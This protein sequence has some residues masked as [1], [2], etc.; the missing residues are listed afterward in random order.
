M[1]GQTVIVSVLADTKKFNSAMAGTDRALNRFAGSLR[2]VSRIGS[3]AFATVTYAVGRFVVASVQAAEEAEAVD[4]KLVNQARNIKEL[5][6]SYKEVSARLLGVAEVQQRLLGVDDD[7][8]KSTQTILL[9]FRPLAKLAGE[10]GGA[11]DR[12][13]EAAFNLAELGF[14]TAEGNA[15]ALGKAL[16]NPTKGLGSLTRLGVVFTEQQ[17]KQIAN[18]DKVGKEAEAYSI[19]LG[20]IEEQSA[21]AG[22]VGVTATQKLTTAWDN[23]QEAFGKRILPTLTPAIE[24]LSIALYDLASSPEF[25]EFADA[26]AQAFKDLVATNALPKAVKGMSDFLKYLKA[27]DK[28]LLDVLVLFN[29]VTIALAV[30]SPLLTIVATGWALVERSLKEVA[31][32]ALLKKGVQEA[33]YAITELSTGF[34]YNE[35]KISKLNKKLTTAAKEDIPK[36]KLEIK[37]LQK[38]NAGWL[39]QLEA[40]DAKL[41]RVNSELQASTN[42]FTKLKQFLF[43]SATALGLLNGG[44]DNFGSQI[45]RVT[46]FLGKFFLIGLVIEGVIGLITGVIDGLNKKFG[47]NFTI[48]GSLNGL[49]EGFLF[50]LNAILNISDAIGTFIQGLGY[51][52]GRFL[53]D[54]MQTLVDLWT[55][56][57]ELL[58]QYSEDRNGLTGPTTGSDYNTV[59]PPTYSPYSAPA[60]AP[61]ASSSVVV[62]VSALAPSPEIGRSVIAAIADY[63]RTSGRRFA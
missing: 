38:E 33:N 40:Q 12:T 44:W 61:S 26:L 63:E 9:T 6:K 22:I 47:T 32:V 43:G 31:G 53:V 54:P 4:R 23:L 20:A 7:L 34:A 45:L 30:L 36:L 52:I 5:S 18:F 17:K 55:E 35:G 59:T 60:M 3:V 48:L 15:K 27:N 16:S 56:F 14:G 46:R 42:W 28:T 2:N 21:N 58:G 39:K 51:W 19:I 49:W 10:V 50:V 62:N 25:L 24:N 11:F 37:G 8:I 41:A 57:L 13:T 29:G 1:A